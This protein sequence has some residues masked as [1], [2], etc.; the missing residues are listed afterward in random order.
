MDDIYD[1]APISHQTIG[2]MTILKTN[3]SGTTKGGLEEM[4]VDEDSAGDTDQDDTDQDD[5]PND[6]Q[7]VNDIYNEIPTSTP[8][9]L[10]IDTAGNLDD[11][12]NINVPNTVMKT[13]ISKSRNSNDDLYGAGDETEKGDEMVTDNGDTAGQ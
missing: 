10:D 5:E 11:N 7:S 6:D 8:G 13:T 3:I 2:M 9:I 12:H 4:L 1:E